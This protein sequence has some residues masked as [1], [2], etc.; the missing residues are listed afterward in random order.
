VLPLAAAAPL[1]LVSDF[2]GG[3]L[4]RL[5][6]GLQTVALVGFAL[7]YIDM[8]RRSQRRRVGLYTF[9]IAVISGATVGLLGLHMAFAGLSLEA[10]EVHVRVALLGF[11]GLAIVGV[12]YQ[13]YPPGVASFPGIDDRTAAAAVGLLAVGLA[14]ESG[15]LLVGYGTAVSAGR[16]LA[17]A[18][19]ALH[20][21]I[22]GVVFVERWR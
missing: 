22:L 5:G 3:A 21:L 15:G 16:G 18:G 1:F 14:V 17:L 20:A 12:S 19:S 6:A 10:A 8:F 13:F 4:F 9:L 11:L 2:G 7:A